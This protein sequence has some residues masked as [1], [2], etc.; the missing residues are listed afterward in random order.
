MVID[1]DAVAAFSEGDRVFHQKFG[2][3][4]IAAIEGDKLEV[5][6]EQAGTKHVVAS[7]VVSAET[8]DDVPF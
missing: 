3:G 7:Y 4:T 8:A 6:F 2:Y 1:L 5:A